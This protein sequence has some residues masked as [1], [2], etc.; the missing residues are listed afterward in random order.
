MS[1]FHIYREEA[2]RLLQNYNCGEPFSAYIKKELA[3]DRRKG[4]RDRKIITDICFR[5]FRIGN[6]FSDKKIEDRL[7]TALFLTAIEG[8]MMISDRWKIYSQV[9]IEEKLQLTGVDLSFSSLFPFGSLLSEGINL[10][11]FQKSFLS[12][13]PVYIRIRPG[14]ENVVIDRLHAEEISFTTLN[15][16]CI[17]VSQAVKLETY[18][19]L[20]KEVVVQDASSQKIVPF[21]Q[22]VFKETDKINVWDCCAASG[23]KSIHLYDLFSQS[24]I[25]VTDIRESVLYNLKN[26]FT[27]AGIRNYTSKVTD[28]SMSYE[29]EIKYDLIIADVPCSGSGTWARI[30]EQITCFKEDD[31]IKFK[32]LQRQIIINSIPNLKTGGYLL[33]ST[34]SAFRDENEEQVLWIKNELQMNC[35][36]SS[37]INGTTYSADT[38][39][40]ALFQKN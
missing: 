33:Y 22:S 1:R 23:G 38:M 6:L 28:L 27:E 39:Y 8:D 12:Q 29:S 14:F 13:P 25:T 21:I 40:V 2:I 32:N 20:N 36:Q 10:F 37:L 4:S 17:S 3:K 19:S 24:K 30:P 34:C 31:L 35:L 7:E 5:F 9:S 26:R 18:F 11:D 16:H 15:D